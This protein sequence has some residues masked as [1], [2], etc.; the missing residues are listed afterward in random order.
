MIRVYFNPDYTQGSQTIKIENLLHVAD[1][2]VPDLRT[3]F[4]LCQ[5]SDTPWTDQPEV[6]P[7]AAVAEGTRSVAPGDV[8]E[9]EG[10][11]YLVAANDF[12]KI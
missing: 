5:N 7:L 11:W 9:M 12:Q 8:L 1:V 3:A 10:E 4:E 2:D 6:T